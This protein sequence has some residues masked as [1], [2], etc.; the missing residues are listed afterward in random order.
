MTCKKSTVACS[1]SGGQRKNSDGSGLS[2]VTCTAQIQFK[3]TIGGF[4]ATQR[5]KS[6]AEKVHALCEQRF[7]WYG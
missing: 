1:F 5:E 6:K 7:K 3:I 4:K 2:A